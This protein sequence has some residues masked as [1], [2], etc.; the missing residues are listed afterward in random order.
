MFRLWV[1]GTGLWV[2][3]Q[4]LNVAQLVLDRQFKL[5]DVPQ[6]TVFGLIFALGPPLAVLLAGAAVFW[7]A[8]G[9]ARS[10]AAEVPA[11]LA[12]AGEPNWSWSNPETRAL[13]RHLTNGWHDLVRDVAARQAQQPGETGAPGWDRSPEAARRFERA[14]REIV[15]DRFEAFY[16]SGGDA[17]DVAGVCGDVGSLWRVNWPELCARLLAELGLVVRDDGHRAA[18]DL[19]EAE[20][21]VAGPT[22][23]GPTHG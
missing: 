20:V 8:G 5:D 11:A 14:L 13:Y 12:P 16:R 2:M 6:V 4:G 10:A 19:P 17:G 23:E 15:E 7:V 18:K 21:M 1:V 22:K 9:F 3:G